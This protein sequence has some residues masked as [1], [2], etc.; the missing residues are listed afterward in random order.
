[1]ADHRQALR[2]ELGG[3]GADGEALE[4]RD[5]VRAEDGGEAQARVSRLSR[6]A[7]FVE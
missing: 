2:A 4:A 5:G 6:R 1:M 7:S 3:D